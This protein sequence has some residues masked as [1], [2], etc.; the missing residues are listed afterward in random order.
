MAELSYLQFAQRVKD[1]TKVHTN[2]DDQPTVLLDQET[3]EF[4]KMVCA[5]AV[6]YPL[7]KGEK[8][9]RAQRAFGKRF[10]PVGYEDEIEEIETPCCAK[11]M[12][13]DPKKVRVGRAN[14]KGTAYL[15][16]ASDPNTALAEMRSWVDA[17]ITIAWF[18]VMRDCRMIDCSTKAERSFHGGPAELDELIRVDAMSKEEKLWG[19][20]GRAFAKP[21][22][23]D[24]DIIEYGVDP[25][26]VSPGAI[27]IIR[28]AAGHSYRARNGRM[29]SHGPISAASGLSGLAG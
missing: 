28:V 1:S 18:T 22:A 19:A 26:V 29:G 20:I 2:W 4:L 11:R 17:S 3:Q 9:Y 14:P 13:P 8:L 15:Y 21:V 25:T 24:D 7:R 6:P 12:Y 10:E 5:S 23:G 27:W 16:L